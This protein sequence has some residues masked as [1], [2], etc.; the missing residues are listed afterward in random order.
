M[1]LY[2]ILYFL[3]INQLSNIYDKYSEIENEVED[4]V[5]GIIE[6]NFE[7]FNELIKK[8]TFYGVLFNF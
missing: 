7:K 4:L 8:P 3:S 2:H 5:D 6:N 1:K